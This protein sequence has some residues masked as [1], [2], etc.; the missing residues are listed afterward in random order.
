MKVT[1]EIRSK[2]LKSAWKTYNA[3]EN[4][5]FSNKYY[6]KGVRSFGE[7]LR[8]TW[9]FYKS[10]NYFAKTQSSYVQLGQVAAET[11]KAVAY[12]VNLE[13]VHTHQVVTRTVWFPKS[14]MQNGKVA[15]WLVGKKEA[16][17]RTRQSIQ[18]SW[19]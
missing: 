16:E 7:I 8:D 9:S 1:N 18:I 13:C 15:S 17:L 2:V 6:S 19:I 4:G 3:Q 10:K 11:L 5:E 12:K 14:Q